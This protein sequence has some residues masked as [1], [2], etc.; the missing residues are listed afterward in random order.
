M[1]LLI[2][3]QEWDMQ[4][5]SFSQFLAKIGKSRYNTLM[6][7]QHI[8]E[9]NY[10]LSFRQE[11][12]KKLGNYL[13]Q[14]RSVNLIGMR[15]VGISNFLRFFLS[16]PEIVPS[17][18]SREQKHLFIPVDLNDLVEREIYPFWTLTLKR[19]VDACETA[20]LPEDVKE[21]INALF[22]TSIQ[23]QDLFLVIDTI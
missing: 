15:R 6:D 18:I 2:C 21:K 17:Y 20:D 16:H 22:L 5:D 12:A 3:R 13:E 10:P 11:D 1:E 14:R 19:V 8:S 23:S 9:S 7:G 4:A